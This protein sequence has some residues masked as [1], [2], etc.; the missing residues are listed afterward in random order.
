MIVSLDHQQRLIDPDHIMDFPGERDPK[1]AAT[2]RATKRNSCEW[3]VRAIALAL[4]ASSAGCTV[5]PAISPTDVRLVRTHVSQ[6]PIVYALA[7]LQGTAKV[8]GGCLSF[9][10]S[11]VGDVTLVY[12]HDYQ[13]ARL[14]G[15]LGVLDAKG[16]LVL[17]VGR[18]V[19]IGGSTLP[20]DEAVERVVPAEDRRD[21]KGP[22]FLV[23]PRPA[24]L[25]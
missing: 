10:N 16:S 20:G 14:D 19:Q 7:P 8:V 17:P 13:M 5:E 11:E 15:T 2:R 23:L 6:E 21:C 22:F 9:S 12:P 18:R 25:L 1:G 4:F 24:E 3:F